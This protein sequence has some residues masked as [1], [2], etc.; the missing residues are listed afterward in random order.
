MHKYFT[1][2]REKYP[3]DYDLWNDINEA[4]QIL[5]KNDYVVALHYEDCGIYRLEFEY[6]REDWAQYKT[7]WIPVEEYEEFL[8]WKFSQENVDK[9]A[10]V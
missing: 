2:D 8:D 1:F 6:E 10:E 3:D 4:I 7:T 5:V 9:N